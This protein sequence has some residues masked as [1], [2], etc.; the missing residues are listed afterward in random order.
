MGE[1]TCLRACLAPSLLRVCV[2]LVLLR[3]DLGAILAGERSWCVELHISVDDDP[4][5]DGD[6]L[7]GLCVGDAGVCKTKQ[8]Q[9]LKPQVSFLMNNAERIP[10]RIPQKSL[11]KCPTNK[12]TLLAA[13]WHL[14]E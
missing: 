3:P 5:N 7:I 8:E 13:D 14:I 1:L 4:L 2:Y 12:Q 11:K 6:L 9:T 10:K